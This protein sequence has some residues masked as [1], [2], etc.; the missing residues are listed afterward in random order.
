MSGRKF[1]ISKFE[2]TETQQELINQW[3]EKLTPKILEM[4]KEIFDRY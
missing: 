1:N 2:I 3:Y 4:Q